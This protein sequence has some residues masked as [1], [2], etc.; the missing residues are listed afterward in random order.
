M[1]QNLDKKEPSVLP[2]QIVDLLTGYT[3]ASQVLGILF[4]IIKSGG[5]IEESNGYGVGDRCE[6]VRCSGFHD[7]IAFFKTLINR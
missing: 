2:I 1:I 6:H 7:D 3:S 5:N 4:K